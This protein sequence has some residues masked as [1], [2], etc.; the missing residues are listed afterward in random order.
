V[1]AEWSSSHSAMQL[2]RRCFPTARPRDA[3][4]W[5]GL[6]LR[7]ARRFSFKKD[8]LCECFTGHSYRVFI[9]Q[10]RHPAPPRG[11]C[12]DGQSGFNLFLRREEVFSG[13]PI[14]T[15]EAT[16]AR[17]VGGSTPVLLQARGIT[18]ECAKCLK[19]EISCENQRLRR[20]FCH[21]VCFACWII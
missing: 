12:Q 13:C 10:C 19:F 9:A 7:T 2:R 6:L 20:R 3:A 8:C 5:R 11:R 14:A 1:L 4:R 21:L 17:M 15:V 16:A 18:A